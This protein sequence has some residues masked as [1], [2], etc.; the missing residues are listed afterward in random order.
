MRARMAI[1]YSQIQVELREV[2]LNNKPTELILASPKATVPVLICPDGTIL[3]ESIDIMHWALQHSDPQN[4]LP[5]EHLSSIS[6]L[7]KINDEQFKLHLDHYKY[8]DRYPAQS[9]LHYRQQGEVFLQS[10]ELRLQSHAYLIAQTLSLADIALM[11]FIRQFA[12][13]DINWF[14]AAPYPQLRHWLNSGL[15]SDLFLSSMHKYPRWQ[16]HQPPVIF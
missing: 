9:P 5:N 3:D 13:V 11:P 2:T 10:L 14:N 4:W 7:I 15:N 6:S 1:R 8:A 12:H 16:P